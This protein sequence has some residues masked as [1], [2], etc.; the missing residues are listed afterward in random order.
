[1]AKLSIYI[2][3]FSPDYSGVASTFFDLN[4]IAV[5][6]DASGCTGNYTGYDEP[7]WYGSHSPIYCSGLREIDAIMGNDQKLIDKVIAAQRDIKAD[8]IA[9]I[10]S[11]VPMVVGCDAKG[12][13]AEIENAT[14]VP[15]FGFDT[16]GTACYDK[17]IGMASAELIRKFTISAP[18]IPGSVNLLGANAIDFPSGQIDSIRAL[19]E[20][21]GIHVNASFPYGITLSAF[22]TLSSASLNIIMSASGIEAARILQKRFGTPYLIGLPY[23]KNGASSFINRTRNALNGKHEDII[24]TGN[25]TARI[26]VMGEAVASLAIAEAL[27]MDYGYSKVAT[28]SL[29]SRYRELDGKEI[30][31]VEDEAGAK[32]LL[33]NDWDIIIADPLYKRLA[34]NSKSRFISYPSYAVS[35]KLHLDM[36]PDLTG[37]NFNEFFNKERSKS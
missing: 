2:P 34:P 4:A 27:R 6:H 3:P 12:I 8:M 16:T 35:S 7:R 13:A 36:I 28:A 14:G 26:L 23:G 31:Y 32:K 37:S 22:R 33:S 10:G 24:S 11:P 5:L 20:E 9:I 1:M 17:G 18:Q 30:I 29:F 19:L 21:N 15:S 25:D